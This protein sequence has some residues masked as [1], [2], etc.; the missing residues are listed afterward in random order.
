[1][2]LLVNSR[3][4]VRQ[5]W[6]KRPRFTASNAFVKPSTSDKVHMQDTPRT[7]SPS[8]PASP[9]SGLSAP[10]IASVFVRETVALHEG[11][12]SAVFVSD[13]KRYEYRRINRP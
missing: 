3:R 4:W 9:A 8:N 11:I 2:L 1:M 5:K 12:E 13:G 7:P 10:E 6:Q